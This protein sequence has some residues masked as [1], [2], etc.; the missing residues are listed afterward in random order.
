MKKNL[1]LIDVLHRSIEISKEDVRPLMK[2]LGMKSDALDNKIYD[3][4]GKAV[5]IAEYLRKMGSNDIATLF[6]GGS[7][8]LYPEV[9]LDVGKKLKAKVSAA[10]SVEKNEEA[11]L[12]KVF[13]D[14]LDQMS[15][16]EKRLL[17]QSMGIRENEYPT[18]AAATIVTQLVARFGG[19]AVYKSALIV[20]NMVSRAL[21]GQGLAFATNATLTR[22]IGAFLGPIGW[23]AS[24]LW[25]AVDLA[26][27][28]YR[29]TVPAIIHVATLRQTLMK[30][31][32]I[33]VVGDGSSGKDSL[34]QAV[35]GLESNIDPVAGSTKEAMAYQLS[36]QGNAH[37]VNYPGFN[38][39]RPDVNAHSSDYLHHTDVF[40]LVVDSSRGIS[41]TDVAILKKVEKFATPDNIL[42]CLN[43]VDLARNDTDRARLFEAAQERLAGYTII[44]TAFDPDPRLGS[45]RIGCDEVYEWI[46]EHVVANGKIAEALP[47][48]Q[49]TDSA[50]KA[51]KA[52]SAS[53]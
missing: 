34:I 8:V 28:A 24:G 23:I 35:F 11:I 37:V 40:V 45:E 36:E 48:R 25:L 18:G 5:N 51:K 6:R 49:S 1:D 7:G 29:K 10:K 2:Y 32:T 43:K 50:K 20:A 21:L 38:D 44:E 12:F 19:F 9:V 26:G 47:P 4:R 17:F 27:P 53:R 41:G 30:R 42:I 15:D 22:T 33:G 16:S 14:A 46:K 13:E 3:A 52:R 31:V 39:Y